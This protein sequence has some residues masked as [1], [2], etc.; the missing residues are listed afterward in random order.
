MSRILIVDDDPDITEACQ[1]F[2]KKDGHEVQCAYSRLEGMQA[3]ETFQ[4][5]LLVLDVMMDQPDDGIAMA[6]DLRRAGFAN[7]I[8]MLTSLSKVSGFEYDKDQDILPVDDYQTKPIDPAT[9]NAKV[10]ELLARTA[11]RSV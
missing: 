4:P 10:R 1:L 11:R 9:L 7:P 3:V 6:Q 5:D 2:L 8:L